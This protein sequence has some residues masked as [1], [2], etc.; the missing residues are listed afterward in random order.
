[1]M[2]S[3]EW[4]IEVFYSIWLNEVLNFHCDLQLEHNNP[5]FWQDTPANDNVS[6]N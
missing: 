1:M 5:M 2:F 3:F 4:N 6:S